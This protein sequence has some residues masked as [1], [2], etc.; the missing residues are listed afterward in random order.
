MLEAVLRG[1]MTAGV[2][3]LADDAEG[4]SSAS[5]GLV[6]HVRDDEA[7]TGVRTRRTVSAE[8]GGGCTRSVLIL[9]LW[10]RGTLGR[11]L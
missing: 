7:E 3:E 9:R 4:E 6:E 2:N 1:P 10:V 11:G 5:G 8:T